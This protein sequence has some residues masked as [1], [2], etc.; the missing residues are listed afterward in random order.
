MVTLG[1]YYMPEGAATVFNNYL[2]PGLQ[3]FGVIRSIRQSTNI[4]SGMQLGFSAFHAGF[5]SIDAAVSQFAL[6]LRYASE[7]KDRQSD[8]EDAHDAGRAGDELSYGPQSAARDARAWHGT[9]EI[10]NIAQLAVKAGLRATV[11]PFWRRRSRGT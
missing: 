11:D 5:T 3:R 2:S 9:P 1:H 8:R 7:G 10:Q 4:L 6:A